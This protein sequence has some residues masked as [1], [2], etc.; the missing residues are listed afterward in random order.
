M[1]VQALAVG[2]PLGAAPGAIR[3]FVRALHA[4]PLPV[5]SARRLPSVRPASRVYASSHLRPT[6]PFLKRLHFRESAPLN[7]QIMRRFALRAGSNKGGNTPVDEKRAPDGSPPK[8]EADRRLQQEGEGW[9]KTEPEKKGET[10]AMVTWPSEKIT[11]V[12]KVFFKPNM[13]YTDTFGFSV[14]M[15]K[16]DDNRSPEERAAAR[17]RA[18]EAAVNID[19]AERRRRMLLGLIL[20]QYHRDLPEQ[21]YSPLGRERSYRHDHGSKP[22][23]PVGAFVYSA[24]L[25]PGRRRVRVRSDGSLIHSLCQCLGCGRHW[26][27]KGGRP[28]GRYAHS[29]ESG[30]FRLVWGGG[31][32]VRYW[33]VLL[34]PALIEVS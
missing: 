11:E 23:E 14:P 8:E 15:R 13:G 6:K 7:T 33:G 16:T 12:W 20:L 25:L 34:L 29:E 5:P 2:R 21:P 18:A 27:A 19:D 10:D 31:F 17:A 24:H 32:A 22:R 9:W 1:V 3:S 30:W 4:R 26:H 28:G